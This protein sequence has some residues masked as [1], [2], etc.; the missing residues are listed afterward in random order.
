[1]T[2]SLYRIL[3]GQLKVFDKDYKLC[4]SEPCYPRSEII[5]YSANEIALTAKNLK[6]VLF[7][8]VED[9]RIS[10]LPRVLDIKQEIYGLGYGNDH[11]GFLLHGQWA[12]VSIMNQNAEQVGKIT[13]VNEQD[14][15]V[16]P[17][18]HFIMHPTEKT[19]YLAD[20]VYVKIACTTYSGVILFSVSVA[21]EPATP[22]GISLFNTTIFVGLNNGYLLAV[23]QDSEEKYSVHQLLSLDKTNTIPRHLPV[24]HNGCILVGSTTKDYRDVIR[25]FQIKQSE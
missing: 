19:V 20:D 15:P 22:S 4:F 14:I 9:N 25:C 8:A 18:K 3:N 2:E 17:C 24:Q 10:Q 21:M 6:Q 13:K 12:Y 7:Y 5:H 1:M 16:Y 23:T 11:F